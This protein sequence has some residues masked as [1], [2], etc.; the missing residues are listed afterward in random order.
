MSPTHTAVLEPPRTGG[1]RNGKPPIVSLINALVRARTTHWL[2]IVK[3]DGAQR[4]TRPGWLLSSPERMVELVRKAGSLEVALTDQ[5]LAEQP[6]YGTIV[7][8]Y[9]MVEACT[10]APV[11]AEP[12]SGHHD[13]HKVR[14]A[15]RAMVLQFPEINAWDCIR[16][17]GQVV[18][19]LLRLVALHTNS[20]DAALAE[21]CQ[22]P[23]LRA[24][25]ALYILLFQEYADSLQTPED[26]ARSIVTAQRVPAPARPVSSRADAVPP[27]LLAAQQAWVK[28]AQ[29]ATGASLI[30]A[31]LELPSSI[32]AALA[33]HGSVS[34]VF[35]NAQPRIRPGRGNEMVDSLI[36]HLRRFGDDLGPLS[37]AAPLPKPGRRS[38]PDPKAEKQAQAVI[39]AT[40]ARL[41]AQ[42]K[43][44][45][46]MRLDQ[47]RRGVADPQ[48]AADA[49][50]VERA[51]AAIARVHAEIK[52][53][54]HGT[55]ARLREELVTLYGGNAPPREGG[56]A[57]TRGGD[58]RLRD[59]EIPE[60]LFIVQALLHTRQFF[61]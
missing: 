26:D 39:D 56:I 53:R 59:R 13:L 15:W 47:F 60:A 48:S 35:A 17:P 2:A 34:A 43:R 33:R 14:K 55:L 25:V 19:E 6:L 46:E 10:R 12:G 40:M 51:D 5:G 50:P 52:R 44:H 57:G 29:T 11:I 49:A 31:G 24:R 4:Y 23:E 41:H 3:T 7:A 45:C 28:A 61:C 8:H 22:S 36:P 16:F 1:L 9:P 54:V 21:L 38:V 37:Q 30:R 32:L 20:L 58:I 42:V 18:A 27:V